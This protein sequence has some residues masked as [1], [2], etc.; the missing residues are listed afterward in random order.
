MKF[1]NPVL[2]F[3][4][5]ALIV[6]G[7]FLTYFLSGKLKEI[8]HLKAQLTV[9]GLN[10]AAVAPPAAPALLKRGVF[11]PGSLPMSRIQALSQCFVNPAIY[12][13]HLT[14]Q[15]CPVSQEYKVL[16]YQIPKSA[17]S[18]S[19][20]IMQKDLHAKEE[21]TIQCDKYGNDWLRISFVR[22]PLNRFW[23]S[24]EEMIARNLDQRIN[25]PEKF[26]GF[27]S[28][29]PNYKAYEA[30]FTQPEALV[31]H[32]HRFVD[33]WDGLTV[34]DNHL[35]LQAPL[36]VHPSTGLAR[37]I[38]YLGEV[39][40]VQESWDQLAELFGTPTLTAIKGR[41][42]PRRMDIKFVDEDH[43]NRICQL[44]AIDY[45][46]LNYKLPKECK[47]SGV[48]CMWNENGKII[49]AV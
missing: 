47:N 12:K 6:W 20:E 2:G 28:D 48:K 27:V 29:L 13:R 40:L 10:E 44:S 22:E 15:Q 3:L 34:F 18:S 11:E 16:Y 35:T 42:Y 25:I 5:S 1:G 33:D 38:S 41:S 4:L 19:R 26:R 21:N 49:V 23:S 24:Y 8:Q 14:S 45:C 37:N 17:S 36:L 7:F 31:K 43:T 9:C 30:L 39:P 32:C 46:C